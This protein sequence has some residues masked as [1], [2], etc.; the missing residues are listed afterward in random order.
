MR[1]AFDDDRHLAPALG[2]GGA[3]QQAFVEESLRLHDAVLRP[4]KRTILAMESRFSGSISLSFTLM[5]NSSSRNMMISRMPVESMMPL[6]RNESALASCAASPNRKF[7][8]MYSRSLL[9][10]DIDHSTR[11]RRLTHARLP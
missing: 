4:T 1:L 3:E 7:A 10:T 5:P 8:V 2:P 6:S 9:S 11:R